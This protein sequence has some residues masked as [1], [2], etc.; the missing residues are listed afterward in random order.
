MPSDLMYSLRFALYEIKDSQTIYHPLAA[1]YLPI[2]KV[3]INTEY[4]AMEKYLDKQV[5]VKNINFGALPHGTHSVEFSSQNTTA[6][7]M[8]AF[9][10]RNTDGFSYTLPY[11]DPDTDS[12]SIL[13]GDFKAIFAYATGN[14]VT[15][16]S[17]IEDPDTTVYATIWYVKN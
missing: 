14:L 16:R 17:T 3:N 15:I 12:S 4:Q 9:V 2:P 11:I 8:S 1:E 5:Y 6:L 7:R 13:S 10:V